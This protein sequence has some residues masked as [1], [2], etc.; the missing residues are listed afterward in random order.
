MTG[1]QTCAL[2]IFTA[3]NIAAGA[4]AQVA[5]GGEKVLAVNV[6]NLSG[7]Q[8]AWTSLLDLEDNH[9][10]VLAAAGEGQAQTQRITDMVKS[11]MAG[12][13][14]ITSMPAS[15]YQS[16]AV[17]LNDLGDGTPLMTDFGGI[18][19]DAD[20]VLTRT[21]WFGDSDVNGTL[22][23][24]DYY[25]LDR[26]YL[27]Q[28]VSPLYGDGDIN[29]DGVVDGRDYHMIDLAFLNQTAAPVALQGSSAVP[30]PGTL[31]LLA[32]AAGM[33]CLRRRR[34]RQEA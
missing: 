14:G 23:G 5:A 34:G 32:L 16:L 3:L 8:G 18:P 12:I 13:A 2:P 6:L 11:G 20:S 31:G 10:A 19:V 24:D 17:V 22:D 9:L 21:T 28:P 30:E 27:A 33:A 7:S 26:G 4:V 15:P 29:Y 25:R 1:V